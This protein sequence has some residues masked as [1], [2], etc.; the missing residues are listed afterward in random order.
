MKEKSRTR[1][2]V[3]D[4]DQRV[5]DS[6]TPATVDL[7]PDLGTRLDEMAVEVKR[8]MRSL[9]RRATSTTTQSHEH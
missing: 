4:N 5:L 7:G 9:P 8:A 1:G 3:A 6:Y 2:F